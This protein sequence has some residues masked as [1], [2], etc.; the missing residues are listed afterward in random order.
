[1]KNSAFY[2]SIFERRSRKK[3]LDSVHYWGNYL[4]SVFT[5]KEFAII[6]VVSLGNV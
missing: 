3:I 1:M 4:Q 2:S 5:Y 6:F